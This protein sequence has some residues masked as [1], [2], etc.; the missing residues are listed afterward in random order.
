VRVDHLEVAL[1]HRQVDRLTDGPAR[2]V[3][4]RR[5]ERELHEVPEVLD[6]AV[7]PAAVEVPHERRPVRGCEH[8]VH[9]ADLDGVGGVA[10]VLGERRGGRR[11]DELPAHARREPNPLA[12]DV[13]APLA[14]GGQGLGVA[15]LDADLLQDAVGVALDELDALVGQDLE[16]GQRPGDERHLLGDGVQAGGL[17]RRAPA[18]PAAPRFRRHVSSSS[19]GRS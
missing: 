14:Q 8:G 9:A 1:V 5:R 15:E 2:V 7:P 18:A 16:R 4:E 6:G 10:S 12:V 11:P 3:K 17:P 13:G 19:R